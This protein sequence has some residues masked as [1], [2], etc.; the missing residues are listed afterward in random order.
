MCFASHI[1]LFLNSSLKPKDVCIWHPPIQFQ[2]REVVDL[3]VH[4]LLPFQYPFKTIPTINSFQ[5]KTQFYLTTFNQDAT[6][7]FN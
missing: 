3:K 6:L 7:H 2:E 4:P 5:V 1:L